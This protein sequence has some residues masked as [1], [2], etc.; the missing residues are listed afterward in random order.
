VTRAQRALLLIIVI[1]PAVL[2]AFF[3][4]VTPRPADTSP[5]Q[6]PAAGPITIAVTG[7][8]LIFNPPDDLGRDPAFARVRDAISGATFGVTTLD[9]NL[10]GPAETTSAESRSLP[11]WP[12]GSEREAQTL[13]QLGFDAIALAN[14]HAADYGVDGALSTMRIISAAGL[15]HAGTGTDLAQARVPVYAGV[16]RR[17]ALIS[18]SASSMPESRATATRADIAGRAGLNPLRYTPHITV[19]AATYQTLKGSVQALNAGP[20]PGESELTMFGTVI[21]KG[22]RTSVSFDVDENDER[23]ILE[24]IT[25]ARS[26][27]EVVIVSLHAHEPAN[28]SDAPAEFIVRFARKAVDAGA[29]IV[30][31][32]GPHRLRGVELYKGGAILYSLGNFV[33]QTAALDFRAAN[34]FDAGTDLYQSAIGAGGAAA[35]SRETPPDDEAWWEGAVALV[36][37]DQRRVD[38]IRLIPVDL[39]SG[40]PVTARGFP[41]TASPEKAT[42]IL[43]RLARLSRDFQTTIQVDGGAGLVR[44]GSPTR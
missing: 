29:T 18:V 5:L 34:V 6:V 12:F 35:G 17:L 26:S 39:A 1:G 10:L 16:P 41:R 31:G 19:D 21:R 30:F 43:D 24:Q 38:S 40:K 20:P 4:S 36:T 22:D 9:L 28:D 23:E 2:F 14:D 7:D 13:R 3:Y 37:V 32:H 8:T 44:G 25:A 27:S 42:A 33:Y 15:L 11:R